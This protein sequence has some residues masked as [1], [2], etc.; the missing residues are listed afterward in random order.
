M[1]HVGAQVCATPAVAAAGEGVLGMALLVGWCGP[2]AGWAIVT[3][4]FVVHLDR[5]SWKPPMV[6]AGVRACDEASV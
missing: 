4:A 6:P 2:G 1:R 5:I 3:V